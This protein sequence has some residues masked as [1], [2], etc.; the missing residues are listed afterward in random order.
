MPSPFFLYLGSVVNHLSAQKKWRLCLLLLAC[1]SS[2]G[3]DRSAEE[4][5]THS[6]PHALPDRPTDRPTDRMPATA[7]PADASKAVGDAIRFTDESVVPAVTRQLKLLQQC[8]QSP[9]ADVPVWVTE[10]FSASSLR[11][12]NLA[13]IFRSEDFTVWRQDQSLLGDEQRFDFQRAF[14]QLRQVFSPDQE[15]H[16][17]VHVYE[18]E[19]QADQ[20]VTRAHIEI[21]GQSDRGLVE[22][23]AHWHV[24]WKPSKAEESLELLEIEVAAF[25][26]VLLKRTKPWFGDMTAAVFRNSKSFS[27]QLAYDNTHW[28]RRIERHHIIDK[29]GH[30][31]L[32]VGDIN[33][34]GLDDLYVCQPGGLPNRLYLQQ[35][36]GSV[37]DGSAEAGVDFHDNTRSA[38]LIDFDNNGSQDLVLATVSGVLFLRNDGHGRF[39][40]ANNITAIVDA[41]SMAAAD[42]DH[43]GDLDIYA[44]RYYRA[45]ADS[46]ALPIPAPYFD[47]QNG[48]ANYLIRNEGEW[49]TSN[50]TLA[51][52][53][54]QN[55]NRFSYAAIWIDFDHDGDQDLYV[56]NDFGRNN[57]YR[58]D[59]I[60]GG[61]PKFT[62]VALKV[63]MQDGAF[64]MSATSGDFDRDGWEDVYIANM[65]SSAGSRISRMA[66]FKP[67]L[68][69]TKRAKYQHL[70]RGNTLFRNSAGGAFEDVSVLSGVTMG[71]WSW[72][73]L[74]TDFD[75]N[76]WPDLIVANGYITGDR[77]QD[78][79]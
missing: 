6:S 43:D 78:D 38:L 55:N 73:S 1:L 31:G 26:E 50:A 23:D 9:D 22:I 56:A 30:H 48:G 2:V 36:D 5:A 8:L 69:K 35:S 53:L 10:R 3:C 24:T 64:G 34:D 72:G 13:V 17:S 32:A 16:F 46:L 25:E 39:T 27:T 66:D 60:P 51:A 15:I 74:F 33:S 75:N 70:A 18:V 57:L 63:G 65:F 21:D 28:R 40:L 76:G 12:S 47:A 37:V 29:S 67:E 41:Y 71:R 19:K 77:P 62:D 68:D 4:I 52:G 42:Y 49:R 20:I 44:C 61:P 79:L 54:D 58:N 14:S 7:S 11:P 45:D 59:G